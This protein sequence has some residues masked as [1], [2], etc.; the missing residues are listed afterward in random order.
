[1][2]KTT[3]FSLASFALIGAVVLGVA[4]GRPTFAAPQMMAMDDDGRMCHRSVGLPP[5]PLSEWRCERA[6]SYS[7][8]PAPEPTPKII[9][10][11]VSQVPIIVLPTGPTGPWMRLPGRE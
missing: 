1:M 4:A 5:A 2:S 11:D 3:R 6:I 10:I 8:V 9:I 7:T